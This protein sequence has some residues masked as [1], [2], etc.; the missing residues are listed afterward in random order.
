MGFAMGALGG[1]KE[2]IGEPTKKVSGK[3]EVETP[4]AV[5][6]EVAT[7]EAVT[8]SGTEAT[9]EPTA[10]PKAESFTDIMERV[11]VRT[12]A[13]TETADAVLNSID[14][15]KAVQDQTGASTEATRTAMAAVTGK[16]IADDVSKMAASKKKFVPMTVETEAPVE[17]VPVVENPSEPSAPA[18]QPSRL[19]VEV[20]VENIKHSKDL[21]QFKSG[22]NEVGVVSGKELGGDYVRDPLK[23]IVVWERKDGAQEVGSPLAVTVSTWQSVAERRPYRHKSTERPMVIPP[24]T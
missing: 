9:I 12:Q 10:K 13:H 6:P 16:E 11:N 14:R 19:P 21:A 20:P 24:N 22:A 8:P 5:T 23:P 18:L 7:P 17:T 4:E 2:Q 1:L 15:Q 3:V